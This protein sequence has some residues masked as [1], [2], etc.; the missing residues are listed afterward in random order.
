MGVG[1]RK[2]RIR[3]LSKFDRSVCR[4]YDASMWKTLKNLLG[5]ESR[6]KPE[7]EIVADAAPAESPAIPVKQEAD[8]SACYEV[9]GVEPGTDLN[10]VRRAWKQ[11]LKEV[12]IGHYSDDKET[13]ERARHRTQQLNE[14]Y[15]TLQDK[16]S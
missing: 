6:T 15:R 8:L 12:H 11:G 14:A 9:L 3:S 16:L 2:N 10:R 5:G 4:F 13:K 7:S 1:Q